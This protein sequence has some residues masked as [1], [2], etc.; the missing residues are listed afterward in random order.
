MLGTANCCPTPMLSDTAR[1][2]QRC[3][4]A[5][6]ARSEGYRADAR[7]VNCRSRPMLR[8][9]MRGAQRSVSPVG[10]R[11]EGYCAD[12]RELYR[13]QTQALLAGASPCL[14]PDFARAAGR[15]V[16]LLSALSSA[17]QHVIAHA[18]SQHSR[19][20]AVGMVG[21]RLCVRLSFGRGCNRRRS[22]W[23]AAAARQLMHDEHPSRPCR[24]NLVMI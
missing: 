14:R 12:C 5:V 3:G 24:L 17:Q 2:G 16:C 9:T 20:R 4:L 19:G 22:R 21:P 8:D 18:T 7:S 1:G 23:E 6:G 13:P 10:A 15:L 11:S